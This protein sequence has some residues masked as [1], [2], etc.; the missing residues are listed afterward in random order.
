[1]NTLKCITALRYEGDQLSSAKMGVWSGDE[2]DPWR[3]PPTETPVQAIV[4]MVRGGH[5]VK[6]LHFVDGRWVPGA[7]LRVVDNADGLRVLE[8]AGREQG[9]P[10]FTALP[11][12]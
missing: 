1:M 3:L 11:R 8:E 2:P 7:H 6:P 9:C 12:F 4:E 5:A 10:G